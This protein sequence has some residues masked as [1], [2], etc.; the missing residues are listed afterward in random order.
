MTKINNELKKMELSCKALGAA[1]FMGTVCLYMAIGA[2][3]TFVSS[4]AF[5]YHISFTFLLQGIVVSLAASA[6]W[7][8]CFSLTKAWGFSIRYLLALITLAALFAVSMLIPA[9]NVVEG[10]FIW[11]ISGVISTLAFGTAVAV[12]S[13][14]HFRKTGS[15]SVLLWEIN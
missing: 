8:L 4:E 3:F 2:L 7:V 12:S 14:I 13:N 9:I 6:V 1:M 15:R 5:Y 10:H 11:V